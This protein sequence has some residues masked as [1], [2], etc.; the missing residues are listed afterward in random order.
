MR[1]AYA[2][3]AAVATLLLVGHASTSRATAFTAA[4]VAS[5]RGISHIYSSYYKG[6]LQPFQMR[7]PPRTVAAVHRKHMSGSGAQVSLGVSAAPTGPFAPLSVV[8]A[9]ELRGD[10]LIQGGLAAQ[11]V[12]HYALCKRVLS[13][14]Y[15]EHHT[16]NL[17]MVVKLARGL[18]LLGAHDSALTLTDRSLELLVVHTAAAAAVDS[19]SPS[20]G[21]SSTSAAAV[22]RGE[23][24]AD[25]G[26]VVELLYERGMILKGQRHHAAAGETLETVAALVRD[27]H[28]FGESHRLIRLMPRLGR[29]FNLN[30]EKQF[31][32]VSPDDVDRV[33][34]VV[35]NALREAED[36][37]DSQGD[38]ASSI[39]VLEAR[40]QIIDEKFFNMRQFTGRILRTRAQ[41]QKRYQ[42]MGPSPTTS[43][44]LALSPTIH[45]PVRDLRIETTSPLDEEGATGRG[46]S[47]KAVDDGNPLRLVLQVDAEKLRRRSIQQHYTQKKFE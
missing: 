28:D 44:L 7:P 13:H 17:D 40:R 27:K 11:A 31:F 5:R 20:S 39:R 21:Q 2:G 6:A 25:L 18:R 37:Y 38:I 4:V 26:V 23:Y 41:K 32:Y 46:Q 8:A 9:T 10:Y 12:Q 35:Q 36:C 16:K 30:Q 19:S 42:I 3:Q 14:A 24:Q 1:R 34:L 33:Y 15:P 22:G 43:E 45:Q 47:F 29:R